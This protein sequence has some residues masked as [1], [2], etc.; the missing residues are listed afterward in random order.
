MLAEDERLQKLKER[1]CGSV[2]KEEKK[3][4]KEVREQTQRRKKASSAKLLK[5]RR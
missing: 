4:S 3:K 5:S 1:R 2:A